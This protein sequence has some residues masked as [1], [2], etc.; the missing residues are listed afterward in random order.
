VP[1]GYSVGTRRGDAAATPRRPR[2]HSVGTSRG[3]DAGAAWIFRGDGS[4]RRRGCH[5]DIPWGPIAAKPRLQRG[6]SAET[7]RGVG[8]AAPSPR[9]HPWPSGFRDDVAA[10]GTSR[11]RGRRGDADVTR[12]RAAAA[13][14]EGLQDRERDLGGGDVVLSEKRRVRRSRP[15]HELHHQQA[16][17][18]QAPEDARRRDHRQIVQHEALALPRLRPRLRPSPS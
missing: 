10:Q 2:G 14:R 5:V 12:C 4:R 1:R 11:L 6:H 18:A 17:G 8:A 13:L 3:D 16:L 7:S 15:R 9:K